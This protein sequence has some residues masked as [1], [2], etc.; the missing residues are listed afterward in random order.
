MI[1]DKTIL[2]SFDI[3]NTYPSINKDRGIAAVN[4]TLKTRAN[5]TSLTDCIIKGL[6]I[7]LKCNN[8]DLAHKTFFN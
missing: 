2:V 6:Q 7:C 1:P 8:L 4:N 5:K 3:V